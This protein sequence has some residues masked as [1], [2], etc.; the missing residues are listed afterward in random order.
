M[1]HADI[2]D[3]TSMAF[4]EYELGNYGKARAMRHCDVGVS[5]QLVH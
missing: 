4:E 2:V 3:G 5:A 1:A